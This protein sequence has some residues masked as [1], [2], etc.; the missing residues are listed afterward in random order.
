M[1]RV[2]ILAEDNFR[3]EELVY[4]M[5]RM[6]EAGFKVTVAARKNEVKGKFGVPVAA[7]K[8]SRKCKA[9]DYDAVIIPGGYAP[10]KMRT[11]PEMLGIVREMDRKGKV[12][13]AICHAGWVI[14]SASI[15]KGR[16]V[17]SYAAIK[18]DMINAGGKW[19]D[20]EVVVDG[21]LVTS[22]KPED[23]PAF[24]REIIRKL[25]ILTDK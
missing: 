23:L 18:D 17:T 8:D 1:A 10:D 19:S 12:V 22:R 7:D 3:D 4:P 16:K 9:D 11:Y 24:C 20:K 6:R 13:A 14:A 25:S 15:I 2:L 5:Y 21:N